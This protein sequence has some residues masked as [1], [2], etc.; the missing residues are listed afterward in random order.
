MNSCRIFL[1]LF[2][3]I[4]MP[5]LATHVA[6][7]ET[8][9]E[10]NVL[11]LGEKQY[12]TDVLRSEAIKALPAEQN[13]TIMTRENI[14]AMLPPG[15]AI[16]D[17]EGSCLVET[18]KNIS[19]DFVAQGHVGKFADNLTITVELYETAGNKLMGSFSSKAPD[20]ET[21]ENELRQKS[22]NLFEKIIASTYGK[23]DLQPAFSNGIGHEAELVVKI[24]GNISKNGHKY[25]RGPWDFA[26]GEHSI[27]FLHPCYE[28][29]QFTVDVLSGKTTTVNNTL[30]PVM[31]Q[32]SI[33]TEFKGMSRDVP[34]FVNG[35]MIGRT[36]LQ[37]RIPVCATVEV[38]EAGFQEIVAMDWGDKDKLEIVYKLK[39]AKPTAEELYEDSV[40]AAKQLA[41]EEAILAAAEQKRKREHMKNMV[42]ATAVVL[43]LAS[44]AMGIYENKVMEDEREKYDQYSTTEAIMVNLYVTP[45]DRAALSEESKRSG[46]H[47]QVEEFAREKANDYD[48]QWD[49]VESARI[50][51]NV[52][53]GVGAGLIGAGALIYFAF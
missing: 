20:I 21:L 13:Y 7:L 18:G 31:G 6:V 23:I 51:R 4:V 47:T 19:A 48:K 30:D 12:L 36:P 45:E 8:T 42:S 39:N 50:K 24:D 27:E 33:A 14:S 22:Q 52:F 28:P 53:Y 29:M 10:S 34:V 43:G 35:V 26:P 15:K 41:A 1:F 37:G 5:A 17:C 2:A 49:K 46:G 44:V 9:A 11:T 38:G 25:T 32:F 16:E 3:L 40:L